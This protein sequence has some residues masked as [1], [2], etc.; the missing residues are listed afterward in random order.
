MHFTDSRLESQT[1][2]AVVTT[3]AF[4]VSSVLVLSDDDVPGY[5]SSLA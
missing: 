5:L 4:N 1:V 3:T 2:T